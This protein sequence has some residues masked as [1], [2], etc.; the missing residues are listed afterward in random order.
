MKKFLIYR[1]LENGY[2]EKLGSYEAEVK[3]DSSTNRSWLLAEPQASHFELPEGMDE[4]TVKP[5]F[6]EAVEAVQ[7]M[8]AIP[9]YWYKEG[10]DN[11]SEN[12]NDE[13]WSYFAGI[14]AV[15]AVAAAPAHW[16][17]GVDA[18]L[19][20]TKQAKQKESQIKA[21]YDQMN[22]DVYAQM[23]QVFGTTNAESATAYN[24]TYKLMKEYPADFTNADLTTEADVLAYAEQKLLEIKN[25]ALYRLQRIK[26]FQLEKEA[27]L[28]S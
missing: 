24:E 10:E 18:N 15:Q 2:G 26:Q 8:D 20:A 22:A 21:A 12:P 17:L 28:N 3:D 16:T 23:T 9:A 1:K 5:V 25:Y 27:I 7:E 14:P 11:V 4:E 13:S 6:V 19:L